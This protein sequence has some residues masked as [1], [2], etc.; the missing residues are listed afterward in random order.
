[1]Q[2]DVRD[3][4]LTPG[5]GRSP[6]GG[7]G[8]PLQNSCLGN[9]MDTGTWW[10]TV[11][12]VTKSWTQFKWFSIHMQSF[13]NCPQRSHYMLITIALALFKVNQYFNPREHFIIPPITVTVLQRPFLK[14]RLWLGRNAWNFSGAIWTIYSEYENFEVLHCLTPLFW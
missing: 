7:H 9:P 13:Y 3:T 5:L 8:N 14:L 2:V 6:G 12:R 11:H 4:G 1:M 10:A